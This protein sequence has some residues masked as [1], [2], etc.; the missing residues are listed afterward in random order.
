LIFG[1]VLSSY[2]LKKKI[3]LFVKSVQMYFWCFLYDGSL[4]M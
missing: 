3:A 4:P 2:F 1:G